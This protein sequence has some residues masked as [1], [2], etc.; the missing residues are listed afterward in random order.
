MEKKKI[1]EIRRFFIELSDLKK[2]LT[3]LN[4]KYDNLWYRAQKRFSRH[5]DSIGTKKGGV[6]GF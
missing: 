6:I 3:E 5:Q 2:E 1:E 4:R